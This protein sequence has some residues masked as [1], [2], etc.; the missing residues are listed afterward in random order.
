MKKLFFL[1]VL[2]GSMIFNLSG[3]GFST[4]PGITPTPIFVMPNLVTNTPVAIATTIPPTE[5][6]SHQQIALTPTSTATPDPRIFNTVKNTKLINKIDGLDEVIGIFYDKT[7]NQLLV[8]RTASIE[9]FELTTLKHLKTIDITTN[10]EGISKNNTQP[11]IN[12]SPNGN[13]LTFGSWEYNQIDGQNSHRSNIALIQIG[14][15]S[16]RTIGHNLS[17]N[18]ST[19]P[20]R[21]VK[22]LPDNQTVAGE[23]DGEEQP[24][25]LW[26]VNTGTQLMSI[27]PF[28]GLTGI[29][30]SPRD[31]TATFCS[32]DGSIQI[33]EIPG[34]KVLNQLTKYDRIS[35]NAVCGVQYNHTGDAVAYYDNDGFIWLF[36]LN[37][38][39]TPKG[40]SSENGI[41]SNLI[42]SNDD[43]TMAIANREGKLKTFDIKTM[44]SLGSWFL[45]GYQNSW[46]N[47]N[48]DGSWLVGGGSDE[49]IRIWDPKTVQLIYQIEG[50]FAV[51]TSDNQNIYV[52]NAQK[53]EIQFWGLEP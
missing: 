47:F 43:Q 25:R 33:V 13:W 42:F 34:G 35:A 4:S 10:V 12:R 46:L 21:I 20:Y 15:W 32:Q 24:V 51:L 1:S 31:K 49:M 36:N 2:F 40:L 22:Y 7:L 29:D 48:E 52:Y 6:L 27:T 50:Q 19:T 44:S 39:A 3:C 37:Q 23:L 53:G 28:G 41:I 14:V 11:I 5:T 9:V 18:L 45:P 8:T 38:F 30:F 17:L 16:L 26:D